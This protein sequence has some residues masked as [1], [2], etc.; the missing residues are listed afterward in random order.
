MFKLGAFSIQLET[1]K[2]SS[3]RQAYQCNNS[4]F[5]KNFEHATIAFDSPS[6]E[7]G[8]LVTYTLGTTR[9]ATPLTPLPPRPPIQAQQSPLLWLRSTTGGIGFYV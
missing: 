6:I 7:S 1:G 2:N 9:S 8:I 3:D 5:S 4:K